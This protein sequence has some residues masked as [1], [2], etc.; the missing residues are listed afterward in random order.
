M[1]PAALDVAEEP[2]LLRLKPAPL[3]PRGPAPEGPAFP[4]AEPVPPLETDCDAWL[5]DPLAMAFES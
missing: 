5:T 3:A 1:L 2:T 4:M